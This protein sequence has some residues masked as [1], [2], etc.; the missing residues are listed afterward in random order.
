MFLGL[1]GPFGDQERFLVPTIRALFIPCEKPRWR[2][3]GLYII[4]R[5]AE[6]DLTMEEWHAL[7]D[8]VSD[9]YCYKCRVGDI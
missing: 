4:Q 8:T 5:K 6:D 1:S 2:F 3:Y 9:D 7:P